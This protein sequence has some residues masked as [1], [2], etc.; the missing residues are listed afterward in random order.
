M[1]RKHICII[2][3]AM[4]ILSGCAKTSLVTITLKESQI[5]YLFP[6]E[7]QS[8]DKELVY[9]INSAKN[10]LDIAIYSITKKNIA[11]AIV[12]AV[13]RGV[14]VRL[15]TDKEM[16]RDRYERNALTTLI[17]VGV[18]V[19]VNSH[20]GL[21]HLKVTIV[22]ANTVTT[23]SYNYTDSATN[24]NDEVLVVL[25]NTSSASIFEKE[26]SRMWKDTGNFDN[27]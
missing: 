9:L 8:P 21:M 7:G 26:F 6:R 27:Y 20:S 1:K 25:H 19:K 2:I 4:I 12:A 15:I 11:G 5:E 18:P 17:D 24:K 22:D 16:S 3:I 13:K 10:S 14:K 23:G